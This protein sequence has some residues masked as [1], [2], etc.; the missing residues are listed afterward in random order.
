MKAGAAEAE[1]NQNTLEEMERLVGQ[2]CEFKVGGYLSTRTPE[3]MMWVGH[4]S[5]DGDRGSA[6]VV[7]AHTISLLLEGLV[8]AARRRWPD[9]FPAVPT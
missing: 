9:L 4:V 3:M 2:S 6:E 1:G 7:L 5:R 8:A